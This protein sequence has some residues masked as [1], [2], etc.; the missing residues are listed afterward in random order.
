MALLRLAPIFPGLILLST[1]C[2]TPKTASHS[3]SSSTD[4][5]TLAAEASRLAGGADVTGAVKGSAFATVYSFEA[6]A[7]HCYDVGV[8]ASDAVSVQF[9][10]Q[11]AEHLHIYPA[12]DGM[13][14][15]GRGVAHPVCVDTA[16]KVHLVLTANLAVGP[17]VNPVLAQV[18]FAVAAR[19]RAES[20]AERTERLRV[21]RAR[22][23]SERRA[24]CDELAPSAAYDCMKEL[25]EELAARDG[26]A[27]GS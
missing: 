22:C 2:S 18:R 26:R 9:V 6:E 8:A 12:T 15:Q 7:G 3:A 21:Q 24:K 17:T 11:P 20:D 10:V 5:A 25:E 23:E 27:G 13:T 14:G 4:D 19:R 1:A 16:G